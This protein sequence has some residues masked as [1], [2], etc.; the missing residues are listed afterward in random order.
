VAVGEVVIESREALLLASIL[1]IVKLITVDEKSSI[2]PQSKEAE[3]I[4][5]HGATVL[6]V[7]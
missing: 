2:L 6:S 4:G 5:K 1:H 7:G 3:Y